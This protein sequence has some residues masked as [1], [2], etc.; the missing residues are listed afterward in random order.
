MLSLNQLR[1]QYPNQ[2]RPMIDI[3]SLTLAKGENLFL[4]GQSGSGKSTLLNLVSGVLSPNSGSITLLETDLG[5]LSQSKKDAFRANHIG[6]IFQNF[7]LIPYLNAEQNTL[8]GCHFSKSRKNKA[9]AKYGNL[10]HAAHAIL[11]SLGLS[12][13]ITKQA[14]HTLSIGQ[15]Q[16][17]AIARALIGEP[18]LIIADEPTSALDENAKKEFI[19]LLFSQTTK[20]HASLLFVSHDTSLKSEFSSQVA[21]CDI[22]VGAQ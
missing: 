13:S 8:L 6:F 17:V 19:Q 11:A 21:L 16:R 9:I 15:Q 12:E 22:N 10:S 4:H 2:L 18:E 5:A 1:F 7:N 3:P 14:V 20:S